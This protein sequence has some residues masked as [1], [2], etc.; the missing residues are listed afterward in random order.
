MISFHARVLEKSDD[1]NYYAASVTCFP[2]TIYIGALADVISQTRRR[3][4]KKMIISPPANPNNAS[5]GNF[6]HRISGR[7]FLPV[8]A[9]VSPLTGILIVL[10]KHVHENYP[11]N[12]RTT[13]HADCNWRGR[14]CLRTDC[15][16]RG[17]V[18]MERLSAV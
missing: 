10:L 7:F 13:Q 5:A 15:Q 8:P 2:R 12:Q 16:R 14:T 4:L 6:D 1:K 3:I 9:Y 18:P 17:D 11:R